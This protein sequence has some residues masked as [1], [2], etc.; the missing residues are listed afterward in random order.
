MLAQ[1]RDW[2]AY[3]GDIAASTKPLID[4]ADLFAGNADRF[5]ARS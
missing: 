3:P 2:W 4:Q 5:F 1:E